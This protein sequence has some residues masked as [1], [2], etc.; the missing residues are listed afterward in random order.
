[1]HLTRMLSRLACASLLCALLGTPAGA[2][3]AAEPAGPPVEVTAIVEAADGRLSFVTQ[4]AASRRSGTDLA[5]RLDA[6]PDVVAASLEQPVYAV[7][8]PDPLRSQQWGLTRLAAEQVWAGGT[9]TGQVVAVLDTGVDAAHPDLA[10]IVAPGLDVVTATGTATIDP[11]GHGTHVAGVV[12]AIG[13]NGFGG[14]GL[15]QGVRVLPVRVLDQSGAGTDGDVARGMVWAVDNGATVLNLSLGGPNP[16]S[17]LTSAV[18]Y[19][20][21]RDVVVIAAAG[22]AGANGDPVLYP[23]AT[24]GVIA[25]GAVRSDD[26]RPTWSST[27][28]HLSLAAPGVGIMSTVPG[29]GHA[30]WSGTS[31]AAPFVAAAAALVRAGEPSLAPAQLRSRLM[32]TA[33]DLG[34]PGLDSQYGAGLVDVLAARAAGLPAGAPSDDTSDQP[35]AEPVSEPVA[36]APAPVAPAPAPVAP[37]PAP[38]APAPV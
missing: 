37:A 17:L 2:A 36:P 5:R 34:A 7:G 13:E 10:G 21:A 12:A 20:L 9:A 1:M 26:T 30:S 14:A 25:V 27:G 23:A 35:V 29:G 8:S 33:R 22:N 32:A 38:V 18:E 4:R 3:L 31:M 11:H 16:S 6:R 24:R 19:A 28:S 15:G